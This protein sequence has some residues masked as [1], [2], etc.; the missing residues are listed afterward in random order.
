V[1]A[2]HSAVVGVLA[3]AQPRRRREWPKRPPETLPSSA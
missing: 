2:A 3:E 1:T